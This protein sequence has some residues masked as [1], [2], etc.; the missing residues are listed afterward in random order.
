MR[1]KLSLQGSSVLMNAMSGDTK[2]QTKIDNSCGS[3][4]CSQDFHAVGECDFCVQLPY[5]RSTFKWKVLSFVTH[6]DCQDVFVKEKYS[7][8]DMENTVICNY[9]LPQRDWKTYGC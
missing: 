5:E 9:A 1:E 4:E 8:T 2:I 3:R 7:R 6:F